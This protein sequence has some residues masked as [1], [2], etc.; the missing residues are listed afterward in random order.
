MVVQSLEVSKDPFWPQEENEEPLGPDVLYLSAIGALM[1]L[2]NATRLNI[3][4]SINLFAR[5]NFSPTRRHWN[6]IKHILW[7][8]KGD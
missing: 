4:F 1:Y 7:Y 3:A 8:F 2:A 5:Y 6:E